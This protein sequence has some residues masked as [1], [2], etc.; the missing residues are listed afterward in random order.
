VLLVSAAACGNDANDDTS[1]GRGAAIYGANCAA[2]HGAALEGTGR[3]P[4]LLDPVYDEI[5]DD[6]VRSAVRNGVEETRWGFGPMPATGGLS[7]AQIG[8]ILV[9]FRASRGESAAVTAP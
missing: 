6:D 9:F 1:A 4:S 7:D 2:C 8:D 3:G 5:S